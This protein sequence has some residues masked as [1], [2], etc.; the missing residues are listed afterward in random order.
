L[1]EVDD[2]IIAAVGAE[3][4]VTLRGVYYRVVSA[5]AVDKTEAGYDLVSRQLLKLRR[6]GRVPYNWIT[7]G[8]RMIYKPTSWSSL[9]RYLDNAAASYRR[10]LWD[11]Q[12]DE[13][14][15]LSEKDA[16]SGAVYPV[17]SKYDVELAITRGYSSETFTH[18]IAETVRANTEA[19]KT[20]WL[21]QL[22]D[23]DPSGLDGW[24]SFQERVRGFAPEAEV[25]FERLAVT[26]SQITAWNLPTR[27]TKKSDSRSKSF[28]GESVEVDAIPPTMLRAI[29]EDAITDHIDAEQLRL[30]RMVEQ[31]ERDVLLSIAG[32]AR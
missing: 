14:I 9:D 26:P 8:T 3:H 25:M 13:V 30:T 27:P 16:I 31:S 11:D 6:D 23:H 19:G 28:V 32:G 10:A 17:T 7:D 18:S 15:V 22:G 29:V 4:P 2:A 20:T 24:R 1:A 5:G 12:D 21:Y